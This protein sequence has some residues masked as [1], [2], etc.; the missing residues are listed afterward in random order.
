M[1]QT[2]RKLLWFFCVALAVAAVAAAVVFVRSTGNEQHTASPPAPDPA[3]EQAVGCL[4][5]IEPEDGVIVVGARSISGQP[6]IIAELR[7]KEGDYIRTGQI[8]AVLNSKDQL[9]AVW[10][11]AEARIELA[12]KRLVQIKTG[13]KEGDIAAQRAEI[14]R[15][16]AELVN[17]AKEYER[18]QKLHQK[19]VTSAS[20]LD[21]SRLLVESKQQMLSQAKERLNSLTEVRQTD[22]NV[23][24]A[25]V[26]AAI[27]E[28]R[29]ARAE[30]DQALIRSPIQGQVIRINARPG[31]EVGLKGIMELGKT[32]RMHVIAEVPETDI[33]RV[34]VGHHATITSSSLKGDIKGSVV[35]LGLKVAKN[36]VLNT[37][38]AAYSDARVVEVKI[39]LED[40][41]SV[42]NLI[43]GQVNVVI[44]P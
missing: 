42:A 8:L 21:L 6:S 33:G 16:Q 11:Q 19:G 37:D 10:R 43:H 24:E 29:R 36:D 14:A 15:L 28:A 32:D 3:Q 4:G 23:A 18:Q 44:K 31:E 1:N 5:R 35:Q 38:P 7:V 26:Q 13:A 17:A 30:F 34:K 22:V 12:Q 39:R 27:A 20:A 25:E 9:E 2:G 40:S 41:R